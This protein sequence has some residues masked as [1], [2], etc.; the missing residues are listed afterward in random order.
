MLSRLVR[1]SKSIVGQ[2]AVIQTQSTPL[3]AVVLSR[4]LFTSKSLEVPFKEGPERD[5]V[6]FPRPKRLVYPGK[7]RLGFLP[8][9]WFTMFYNRTGVTG[10]YAFGVG[11]VTFFT[12]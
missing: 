5:L 2:L 11:F 6:N 4:C 1:P 12:Q 3:N 8:D 9:E 7:V 10:P